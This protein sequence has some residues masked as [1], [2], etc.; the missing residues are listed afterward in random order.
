MLINFNLN[1][2]NGSIIGCQQLNN[3]AN[4]KVLKKEL[5]GFGSMHRLFLFN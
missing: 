2:K 3:N 5:I 1:L 4:A